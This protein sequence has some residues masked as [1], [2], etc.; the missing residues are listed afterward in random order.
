MTQEH[1]L[2]QNQEQV[3]CREAPRE[4]LLSKQ[5]KVL[6]SGPVFKSEAWEEEKVSVNGQDSQVARG[7]S[8]VKVC[9]QFYPVT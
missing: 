3:V 6:P 4:K 1:S 2:L 9:R 5:G 7:D 8:F